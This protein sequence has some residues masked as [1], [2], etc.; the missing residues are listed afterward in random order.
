[1]ESCLKDIVNWMSINKLKLNTEKT[2]L[3][4]VNSRHQAQTV[5]TTLAF[6]SDIISPSDSVR[7]IGVIFDRT[8][9]MSP[10]IN[11]V[12]KSSFYHLRNIARI[13]KYL[14][15]KSTET[16]AH[17]FIT[18]KLDYC[19]SLIDRLPKYLLRKVQYVRNAARII[20]WSHKFDHIAPICMISMHWLA[21]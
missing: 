14:S 11:N 6:G 5:F 9:S 10:H 21:Y 12:C 17:A 1:M 2:E 20:T 7:N 13:R 4:D 8:L 3:L 18:S 19:N 15:L 16:L